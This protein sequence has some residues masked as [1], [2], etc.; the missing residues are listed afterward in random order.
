MACRSLKRMHTRDFLGWACGQFGLAGSC[1]SAVV[2]K[3]WPRPGGGQWRRAN[4]RAPHQGGLGG[5]ALEKLFGITNLSC[6]TNTQFFYTAVLLH[7]YSKKEGLGQ[8]LKNMRWPTGQPKSVA[9]CLL[10]GRA[11]QRLRH[12]ASKS[13]PRPAAAAAGRGQTFPPVGPHAAKLWAVWPE[14]S[15]VHTPAGR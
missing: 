11:V 15:L 14:S 7:C 8:G 9:G 6:L 3:V 5:R 2:A 10:A 12:C 1:A 4:S 13:W